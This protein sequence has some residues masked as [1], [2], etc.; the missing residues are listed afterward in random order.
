MSD[1][2]PSSYERHRTRRELPELTRQISDLLGVGERTDGALE[3]VAQLT[4]STWLRRVLMDVR[5]DVQ[6]GTSLSDSLRK[7]PELFSEYYVAVVAI[8]ESRGDVSGAL[9]RIAD[10]L[11]RQQR[12]NDALKTA[13]SYPLLVLMVT[14]IS[15]VLMLVYV[16]PEFHELFVDTGTELPWISKSVLGLGGFIRTWGMPIALVLVAS[17][18]LWR[19]S[20]RQPESLYR[21]HR[22]QLRVP[23]VADL[24]RRVDVVRFSDSL[25]AAL[26]G[27]AT[28]VDG[29]RLS[30]ASMVNRCLRR[31][32]NEVIDAVKDGDRLGDGLDRNCGFPPLATRMIQVG[33]ESGNLETSLRR[34]ADVYDREFD[35]TLKRLLNVVEPVLIVSIGAVVAIIVLAMVAAI[36][37]LNNMPY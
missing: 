14:G 20:L 17:L 26:S 3:T 27:G 4:T 1:N 37:E 2:R 18:L 19:A 16:L 34:V 36:Q 24:I 13:L 10:Q 21:W 6:E 25:A 31:S 8:G 22:L 29:L 30:Q 9:C 15:L 23:L 33:E 28:L 11:L 32:L 35:T 5:S 12:F 7:H